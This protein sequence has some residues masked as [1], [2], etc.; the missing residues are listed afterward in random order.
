MKI[1]GL[2]ISVE[3]RNNTVVTRFVPEGEGSYRH[4]RATLDDQNRGFVELVEGNDPPGIDGTEVVSI[5]NGN[6]QLLERL[7]RA[8]AVI[9]FRLFEAEDWYTGI[10]KALIERG[11]QIGTTDDG[12]H[13]WM[14]QLATGAVVII[15]KTFDGGIPS[16]ESEKA[17]VIYQDMQGNAVKIKEADI[18][19]ILKL[20]D[21]D[22]L[23]GLVRYGG[24]VE[25]EGMHMEGYT[26]H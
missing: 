4:I 9:H 25:I 15:S 7:A 1:D 16:N 11:F 14:T 20:L 3:N 13:V 8:M 23:R 24:E 12:Q 17:C 10:D 22:S 21:N 5:I 18:K 6:D 19:D 2:K 26:L